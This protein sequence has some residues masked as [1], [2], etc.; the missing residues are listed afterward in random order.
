MRLL[1][2]G[3]PRIFSIMRNNDPGIP[4]REMASINGKR[5]G[6]APGK[7]KKRLQGDV[8]RAST[9]KQLRILQLSIV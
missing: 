1:Q 6:A 9:Y 5:D 7:W 3:M 8:S 2:D 4:G